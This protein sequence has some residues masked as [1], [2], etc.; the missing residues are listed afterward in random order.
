MTPE[1]L[2]KWEHILEGVDKKSIPPIQFIKKIVV[3]LVGKKQ[4]TINVQLLLKQG[5][6]P[7]EVEEVVA[8]NLN[9]LDDDMVSFEVV[10]NVEAIAQIVQPETDRLLNKL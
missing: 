6:E 5:L 7:E 8:R 1:Y 4:K 10:L 9:E 2:K 3:R